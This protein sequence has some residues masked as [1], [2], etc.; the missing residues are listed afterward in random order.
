M[1]GPAHLRVEHLAITLQDLHNRIV[2]KKGMM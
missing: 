1:Q 2:A